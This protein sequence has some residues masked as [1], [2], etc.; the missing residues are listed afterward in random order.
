MLSSAAL[1]MELY[2]LLCLMLRYLLCVAILF[3]EVRVLGLLHLYRDRMMRNGLFRKDAS[4]AV[5]VL[6]LFS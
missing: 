6:L 1:D 2:G 5:Y 4:T 3:D